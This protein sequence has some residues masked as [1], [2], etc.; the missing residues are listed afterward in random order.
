[1]D[2]EPIPSEYQLCY[3]RLNGLHRKLKRDPKLLN[4]YDGVI[5]EQLQMG[6]IEEAKEEKSK[7][8]F[9]ENIHYLPHHA[10]L[11]HYRE[12]TK[13]RIVY[14]GS[15]K[16]SGNSSLN[17]CLQVGPN[18]IPQ[19]FD[20]LVKF[21]SNPIALTADIEKAGWSLGPYQGHPTRI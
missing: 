3:N 4:E 21:R 17:D 5:K 8:K 6:I 18:L 19:L 13:V 10:V 11:R 15:A 9:S 7:D 12:T 14:D 2:R 16:T 1:M 20:V